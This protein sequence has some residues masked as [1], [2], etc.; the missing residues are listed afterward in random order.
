[1]RDMAKNVGVVT[2]RDLLRGFGFIKYEYYLNGVLMSSV[3]LGNDT[4]ERFIGDAKGIY[5]IY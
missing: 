1:M 3:V 4:N 2:Y 5:G